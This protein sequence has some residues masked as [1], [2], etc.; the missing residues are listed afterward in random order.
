MDRA[1]FLRRA[2]LL[3]PSL[4]HVM[5]IE[6]I[7]ISLKSFIHDSKIHKSSKTFLGLHL[8]PKPDPTHPEFLL[9]NLTCDRRLIG[10]MCLTV[11]TPG[12]TERNVAIS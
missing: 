7:Y 2:A 4:W 5:Q 12:C 8:S 6:F 11:E 10:V 3:N 9:E 1:A